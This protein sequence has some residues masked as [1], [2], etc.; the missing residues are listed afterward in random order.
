MS[1]INDI[2]TRY[3]L[4]DNDFNRSV[5]MT[6]ENLDKMMTTF[7]TI[8]GTL[9]NFTDEIAS[10]QIYPMSI[11]PYTQ[12]NNYLQT[13]RGVFSGV[14]AYKISW[15]AYYQTLGEYF[16]SPKYNNFADYK[17]YTQIKLYLPFLGFVDVDVNECMGKY[18]QFRLLTDFYTGKGLY[19]IGVSDNSISHI[20]PP[21]ITDGED[22]DMRIIS[23]F[24]CDIGINIP[25]GKSN[26]S[27]IRMNGAIS[28][29]KAFA[30]LGI[31]AFTQSPP[32][33]STTTSVKT[34]DIQ[35]RGVA[36][37]SRMKQLKSGTET[38]QTTR[39]TSKPNDEK[40]AI[41]EAIDSSLDVLNR[42]VISGNTDRVG[43]AGLL[44]QTSLSVQVIIY[45]P[46]MLDE[47]Y[48]YEFLFGK[49]VG[50]TLLLSSVSGYT[51][52]T[53]I[54]IEGASFGQATASELSLLETILT[55]SNGIILPGTTNE[56]FKFKVNNTEYQTIP[57][58]TWDEFR[59]S[60][61]NINNNFSVS[62]SYIIYNPT[63][64][65]VKDSDGN[66]VNR[67]AIINSSNYTA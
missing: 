60:T 17:G 62:G 7:D 64:T 24:E 14:T 63:N 20:E 26:M 19:I 31:S 37:G 6:R 3:R 52:I 41:S 36:K 55:S 27:Q 29:V 56:L 32:T 1:W 46:K 42:M 65:F 58:Y 8:I 53:N 67:Q 10:V 38:T 18:L 33:T 5:C 16:V 21:Y 9:T 30:S 59:T 15:R 44:Y 45:R 28:T 48:G 39:V 40:K 11:R 51:E 12:E 25:L 13:S 23:T 66:N 22:D 2:I 35:G 57:N 50:A 4:R 54:H 47:D 61:Y 43:D 49:P 34:Y